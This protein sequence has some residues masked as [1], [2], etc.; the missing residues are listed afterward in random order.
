MKKASDSILKKVQEL[1]ALN[2]TIKEKE[3]EANKLKADI[4]KFMGNEEILIH[5]KTSIELITWK[6]LQQTKFDVTKFKD[7]NPTRYNSYCST[8]TQRRFLLKS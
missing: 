3:T 1:K 2:K 7:E 8:V 5:P 6:E 4:Q